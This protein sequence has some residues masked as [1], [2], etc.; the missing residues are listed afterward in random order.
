MDLIVF[1]TAIQQPPQIT[2]IPYTP[3]LVV[4]PH[5]IS[6]FSPQRF[7]DEQNIDSTSASQLNRAE[8]HHIL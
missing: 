7:A 5:D 8:G 6:G 4:S 1:T 3:I 2:L